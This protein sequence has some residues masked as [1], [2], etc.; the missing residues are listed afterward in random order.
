MLRQRVRRIVLG[1]SVAASLLGAGALY[2]ADEAIEDAAIN[3]MLA[4]Q[5]DAMLEADIVP[6]PQEQQASAL[7]YFRPARTGELPPELQGL[8]EGITEPVEVD[9]VPYCIYKRQVAPG[10]EAYLAYPVAFV[11]QRESWLWMGVSITALLV[12]LGTWIAADRTADRV[13]KPYLELLEQVRVLDPSKR[14]LRISVPR[15][16]E[17]LDL[18][19]NA[20]NGRLEDIEQLIERER[21]FSAAASHELRS[22]L[23]VISAAAELL[24]ER[25]DETAQRPLQRLERGARDMREILDALLALSRTRESPPLA[26]LRLEEMLP[27]AA[28]PHM[29]EA[30]EAR[31]HWQLLPDTL[32]APPGAVRVVFTNLF[33]N[34]LQASATGQVMVRMADGI[35]VVEDQGPGVPKDALPHLF[36][37][38]FHARAGGSGMGLYIAKALS[39]RYGWELRLENRSEGGA[40]ATWRYRRA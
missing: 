22:P 20:L 14:H 21:A 8:P 16:D 15:A 25:V 35:V 33:R 30:A 5:M 19:V 32:V 27:Q 40:R 31:V 24:R 28:E 11:E 29:D 12:F 4:K 6:Q 26:N 17:E 2:V 13:L 3:D 7:K 39:E 9:G 34:A 18:V 38:G 36:E 1:L 10:D 23:T 37:P